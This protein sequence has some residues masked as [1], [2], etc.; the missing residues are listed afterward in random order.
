MYK[1]KGPAT[2]FTEAEGGNGELVTGNV[3]EGNGST[4][5]RVLDVVQEVV[6]KES[7][8]VPFKD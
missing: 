4:H 5:V 7:R 6:K 1:V 2:L 3:I 8:K